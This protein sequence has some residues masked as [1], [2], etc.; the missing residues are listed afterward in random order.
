MWTNN[1]LEPH[2]KEKGEFRFRL[3]EKPALTK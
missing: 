1:A 3:R 2:W